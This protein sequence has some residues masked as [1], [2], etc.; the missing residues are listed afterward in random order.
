MNWA[1]VVEHDA[2]LRHTL[3]DVL[4]EDGFMC[5]GVSDMDLA[6]EALRLSPHALVVL[7][8]H[9]DPRDHEEPLPTEA[10]ALPRHA[11]LILS[12][13]PDYAPQ[14]YN[15]HTQRFIPVVEAPYDIDTLLAYVEEAERRL[16]TDRITSDQTSAETRADVKKPVFANVR[17]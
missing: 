6:R 9:G 5:V 14:A 7:V 1:L 2:S 13:R 8:G 11:Y 10:S 4:H 3:E 12:T 17:A 15:P 16:D